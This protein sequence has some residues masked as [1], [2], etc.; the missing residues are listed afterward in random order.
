MIWIFQ[1]K[2]K[3][4]VS[5]RPP[6]HPHRAQSTLR[7]LGV[8][9][10]RGFPKITENQEHV[11][12]GHLSKGGRCNWRNLRSPDQQLT[13][14]FGEQD[15]PRVSESFSSNQ[16]LILAALLFLPTSSSTDAA[17][18]IASLPRES[19]PEEH[20]NDTNTSLIP[21]KTKPLDLPYQ[22]GSMWK[23]VPEDGCG[24]LGT[25]A[26]VTGSEFQSASY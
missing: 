22:L 13:L 17:A 23:E 11:S 8:V 10:P 3:C 9:E 5:H 21:A 1:K 26:S 19:S 15:K 20:Q 24:G 25:C 4:W 18:A 2:P 16:A 12:H 14:G 6:E 7:C